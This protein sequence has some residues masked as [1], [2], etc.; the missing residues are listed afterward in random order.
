MSHVPCGQTLGHGDCCSDGHLCDQCTEIVELRTKTKQS[1]SHAAMA[2]EIVKLKAQI[3]ED[4]RLLSEG[5]VLMQDHADEI[6]RLKNKIINFVV[7]VHSKHEH[8]KF[9]GG[10]QI[11]E[12]L[13][14]ISDGSYMKNGAFTKFIEDCQ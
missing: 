4:T 1:E 12:M 9:H 5:A 2:A 8:D 3:K 13:D 14:K 10:C 6:E 11:C 7:W